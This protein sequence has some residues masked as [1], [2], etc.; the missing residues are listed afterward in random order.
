MKPC[1]Y[2][3]C[4]EII[5][6]RDD[7]PHSE[8]HPV[9]A[10][11]ILT[12]ER[13][14]GAEL[15]ETYEEFLTD[16]GA[17]NEFG[18]TAW[19]YHFDITRPGNLLEATRTFAEEQIRALRDAGRPIRQ[20]PSGFLAIYDPCDGEIFG[21]RLNGGSR[22]DDA[23]W[24]WDTDD[25]TQRRVADDFCAFLDYLLEGESIEPLAQARL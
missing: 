21:F 10:T 13:E 20:F 16:V 12:V 11:D 24:A 7:M 6:A 8:L 14:L 1:E 15:P 19:W 23:V 5:A 25:L 22:Y 3:D 4:L 18:G 17:G 9:L 2:L